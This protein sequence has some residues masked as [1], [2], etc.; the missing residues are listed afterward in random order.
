MSEPMNSQMQLSAPHHPIPAFQSL[1][2]VGAMLSAL[3]VVA[4]ACLQSDDSVV[5]VRL[6]LQGAEVILLTWAAGIVASAV[7]L[8][9]VASEVAAHKIGTWSSQATTNV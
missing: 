1:L 7:H 8:V 4:Y 9:S 2:A 6:I 3:V 5:R